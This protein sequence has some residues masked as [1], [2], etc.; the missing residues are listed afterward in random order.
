MAMTFTVKSAGGVASK[1]QMGRHELVFDQ[2]R[3]AGGEGKGPGPLVAFAVAMMA[4]APRPLAIVG[5]SLA[6]YWFVTVPVLTAVEQS[7]ANDRP[8]MLR[9]SLSLL[10][11]Q[12]K[13]L[14][15][16]WLIPG[17][18]LFLILAGAWPLYVYLKIDNALALWGIEYLDRFSGKLSGHS[19][20]FLYYIPIIFGLTAPF[21]LSI[22]EAVAAPFLKRY[23]PQRDGLA[24][25]FT[26]AV[27]GTLFLSM[28][29]FKR[30]YYLLSVIPAY[31]LLLAPVIDRLFFGP[32]AVSSRAVQFAC[33]TLPLVLGAGIVAG[34]IVLH[35][36]Y[37][38]L[39]GA[40]V[41][42]G[43]VLFVA[44][45]AACRLYARD[46]RTASFA[47]LLLGVLLVSVAALPVVGQHVNPNAEGQALAR[48]LREHGVRTNDPIYWVGGRPDASVEFYSGFQIQRLIN[49][50][51]MTTM[52]S[53]RR[54]L[55]TDLYEEFL[56]RIQQRL[57]EP[58][59]VYLI[60]TAGHLGMLTRKTDMKPRV[61]FQ[62][63][64]FHREP[65]EEL[66]VITQPAGGNQAPA[67][68]PSF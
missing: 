58:H 17:V 49:E 65:G 21:M 56:I 43:I 16:L 25:A 64:G 41:V 24:F 51:E 4:K 31:C 44:W 18:I 68:K 32:V 3:S 33:R 35:R 10:T 66:I 52:R 47:Q 48:A 9:H 50:I 34:G 54:T 45:T 26:W 62:L 27:V 15:A 36:T 42:I 5:L 39:L 29:S 37:P 19:K 14:P 12:C 28:A 1:V 2:P 59:P 6:V 30:P 8:S 38:S 46:A 63:D 22:P 11:Q 20:P 67:T 61:L 7:D 57:D 53:D 40:Y 23:Q 13:R 55:S 60:M